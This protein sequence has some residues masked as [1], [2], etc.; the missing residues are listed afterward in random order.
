MV[1]PPHA[2]AAVLETNSTSRVSW[3]ELPSLLQLAESQC[4]AV[5]ATTPA[6]AHLT[7]PT[8]GVWVWPLYA[9]AMAMLCQPLS[10][11][12]PIAVGLLLSVSPAKEIPKTSLYFEICCSSSDSGN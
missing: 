6:A 8:L 2:K 7:A 9:L 5:S 1:Y 3:N 10:Q 11:E 4:Y 12:L